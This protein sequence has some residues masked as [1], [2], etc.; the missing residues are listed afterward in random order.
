MIGNSVM[1]QMEGKPQKE[2]SALTP[3][4]PFVQKCKEK[5]LRTSRNSEGFTLPRPRL[6]LLFK[7]S[8]TKGCLE[9]VGLS[10]CLWG[11]S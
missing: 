5:F 2:E 10:A 1:D 9:Q 7:G 3:S 4:V 8:V 11:L 6:S